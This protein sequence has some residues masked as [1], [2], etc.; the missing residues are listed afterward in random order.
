MQ[1]YFIG[2][3]VHR[4]FSQV[5]V[6]D[7]TGHTVRESKL[8]HEDLAQMTEFFDAFAT[9]TQ[10][11]MEATIGWIWIADMLH[12]A[13]VVRCCG[14]PALLERVATWQPIVAT[15]AQRRLQ[16]VVLNSAHPGTVRLATPILSPRWRRA[17]L[18]PLLRHTPQAA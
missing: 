8:Y 4:K 15:V 7:Q 3:D 2:V 17:A 6:L 12:R 1:Q 5:C 16:P 10:L 11:A 18:W 9:G 13:G 14:R